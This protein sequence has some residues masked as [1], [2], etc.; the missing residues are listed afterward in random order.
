MGDYKTRSFSENLSPIFRS[1]GPVD[2]GYCKNIDVI[3]GPL[4]LG[5]AQNNDNQQTLVVAS[6]WECSSFGRFLANA[7]LSP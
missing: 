1:G 5:G 7:A 3:A 2:R 4:F 6:C